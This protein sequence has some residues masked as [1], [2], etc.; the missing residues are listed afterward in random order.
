M[1]RIDILLIGPDLRYKHGPAMGFKW[2][3]D[4][5]KK[6]NIKIRVVS[7][8]NVS[9]L[10]L[11]FIFL[12][13]KVYVISFP[14]IILYILVQLFRNKKFIVWADIPFTHMYIS[15]LI[16]RQKNVLKLFNS[17]EMKYYLERYKYPL[18][19]NPQ[20]HG[21]WIKIINK[22]PKK[23]EK[24]F[25]YYKNINTWCFRNTLTIKNK[26]IKYLDKND[27]SYQFIEYGK[28]KYTDWVEILKIHKY[29][30]FITS[31]ETFWLAKLEA[32]NYWVII[33]N[34][35]QTTWTDRWWKKISHRSTFPIYEP[36][37]GENFHNIS[38]FQEKFHIMQNKKYS[39]RK[40]VQKKYCHI[41]K[42]QELYKLFNTI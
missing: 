15:S 42:A 34:F 6:N 38:E 27:E 25:I 8:L 4:G 26:I 14:E 20:V 3:I 12:T 30:I 16:Y 5:L 7:W 10:N 40:I 32:L 23:K 21:H 17:N 2:L 28:Y 13:K 35:E 37:F 41:K 9:I 36:W 33:L 19:N 1:N 22:V 39:P 29:G 24:I 18:V 31:L 11:F